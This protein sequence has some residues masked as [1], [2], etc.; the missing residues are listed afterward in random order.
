MGYKKVCLNCQKAY[1][2]P[3]EIEKVRSSKC[4]ECGNQM[5][6]LSHLFQPP[7]QTDKKKWDVVKFL[8]DNGFKYYHVWETVFKNSKGEITGYQNYAKYPE[9]MKDAKEFVEKYKEQSTAEKI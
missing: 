4:P 2:R 9:S 6:E 8:V 5:E 1:N 3:F 7:K